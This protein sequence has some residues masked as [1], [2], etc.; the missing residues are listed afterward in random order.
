MLKI[1]IKKIFNLHSNHVFMLII[2]TQMNS[3]DTD[4]VIEQA[5]IDS[6]DFRISH[7]EIRSEVIMI[8]AIDCENPN[9]KGDLFEKSQ[10]FSLLSN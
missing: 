8:Y 5:Y 7:S 2:K 1:Y 9:K 3:S 4:V 6:E 10:Y